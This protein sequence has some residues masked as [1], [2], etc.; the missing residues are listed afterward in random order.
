MSTHFGMGPMPLTIQKF[1][2][3]NK[4]SYKNYVHVKT[5]IQLYKM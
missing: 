3:K 4:Q 2:K 1:K 5:Y